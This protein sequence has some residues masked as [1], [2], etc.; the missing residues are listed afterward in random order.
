M[1]S[2]ERG[3]ERKYSSDGFRQTDWWTG[4]SEEKRKMD[5]IGINR[6]GLTQTTEILTRRAERQLR[7]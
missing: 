2:E 7:L 5:M 1:S 4:S 6:L 3:T